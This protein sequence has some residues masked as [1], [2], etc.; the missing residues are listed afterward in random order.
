M[1]RPLTYVILGA[2]GSGRREVLA[3][4]LSGL[5]PSDRVVVSFPAAE[6][7]EPAESPLAGEETFVSGT[8]RW[9]DGELEAAVPEGTTHF[10]FLSD[11]TKNPVDQVEAFYHWSVENGVEVARL[12]TIVHCRLAYENPDLQKWY[13][14]CIHFSDYVLL[15]RREGIPEKW[16]KDFQERYR[17]SFYPCIFEL[18]KKGRVKN[19]ALVLDPL[20][21]RLTRLFDEEVDELFEEEPDEAPEDEGENATDP[22]LVRLPSG[23]REREIPDIAPYLSRNPEKTEK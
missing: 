5:S 22:Y 12:L 2:S 20:A 8:W 10:F 13:D 15:N 6:S 18:V 1:N 17:K 3:D 9:D 11:G 4:L 7:P 14:A 16:M 23:K 19:P 21:R